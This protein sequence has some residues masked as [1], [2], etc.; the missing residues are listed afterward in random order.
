MR[1]F[2]AKQAAKLLF[3]HRRTSRRAKAAEQAGRTSDDSAMPR[4]R[5]FLR[6][7]RG[8]AMTVVVF[9]V[10]REHVGSGGDVPVK[11][12]RGQASV[13]IESDRPASRS[14]RAGRRG[15]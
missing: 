3:R 4:A 12:S 15:S 1:H 11:I 8:A 9:S 7:G 10:N 5:K 2:V 6:G 13:T 14:R